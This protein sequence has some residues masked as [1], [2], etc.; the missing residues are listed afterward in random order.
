MEKLDSRTATNS[1]HVD[2]QTQ[3][4]IYSAPV[5]P[6]APNALYSPL[7]EREHKTRAR[8]NKKIVIKNTSSTSTW[9][10]GIA[11]RPR[12]HFWIGNDLRLGG[13]LLRRHF[14]SLVQRNL[15]F[16]DRFTRFS[17]SPIDVKFPSPT[18]LLLEQE[19]S[20]SHLIR[21]R[22]TAP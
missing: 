7:G 20:T 8:V 21:R 10:Q 6:Q 12:I 2:P 14:F 18:V 22:A 9:P 11:M 19:G 5:D 4:P 17:D 15:R 3:N 13:K 16:C 1:A